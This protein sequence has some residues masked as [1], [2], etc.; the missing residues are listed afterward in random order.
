M[1]INKCIFSSDRVRTESWKSLKSI[2]SP[3]KSWK[4]IKK[5]LEKSW[6]LAKIVLKIAYEHSV[7]TL[8]VKSCMNLDMFLEFFDWFKYFFVTRL[9]KLCGHFL[10]VSWI[11]IAHRCCVLCELD[12]F[13]LVFL[14]DILIKSINAFTICLD[15]YVRL[16]HLNYVFMFTI[17]YG[18][19]YNKFD[20]AIICIR[21]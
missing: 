1:V 6:K 2:R 16:W 4:S 19:V 14:L 10:I 8:L 21:S 20:G 15:I 18:L 7:R 11:L 17:M 12:M 9:M 13:F 5:V 3:K